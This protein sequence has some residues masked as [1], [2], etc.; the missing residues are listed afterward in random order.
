MKR[1]NTHSHAQNVSIPFGK[2]INNVSKTF[3]VESNRKKNGRKI[4]LLLRVHLKALDCLLIYLFEGIIG[5]GNVIFEFSFARFVTLRNSW[6]LQNERN[7]C[8]FDGFVVVKSLRYSVDWW[9]F[10]FMFQCLNFVS[11]DRKL[12]I[13]QTTAVSVMWASSTC[14][15]QFFC[16]SLLQLV[17]QRQ[18]KLIQNIYIRLPVCSV[19]SIIIVIF[20]RLTP[21]HYI[22]THTH[23]AYVDVRRMVDT[24]CVDIPLS[25]YL[26]IYFRDFLRS[27][28]LFVMLWFASSSFFSNFKFRFISSALLFLVCLFASVLLFLFSFWTSLFFVVV[29]Y[30][31]HILLYTDTQ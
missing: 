12:K 11:Y 21:L 1:P 5:I 28:S 25:S 10:F 26:H 16:F 14:S 30:R 6:L 19:Y 23:A 13:H 29:Q 9:V 15:F 3:C 4:K 20:I 17:F 7:L 18:L 22:L 27:V 2:R 24:N 8:N 31:Y